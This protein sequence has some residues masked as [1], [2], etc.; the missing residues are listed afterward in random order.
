MWS[1]GFGDSELAVDVVA[2]AKE[3]A[4]GAQSAGVVGAGSE[5]G[6]V[7]VCAD[8]DRCVGLGNSGRAELIKI[9]FA[10]AKEFAVPDGA[11]VVGADAD[12]GGGFGAADPGGCALDGVGSI[13]N[14]CGAPAIGFVVAGGA[15]A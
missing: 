4:A 14:R 3:V 12:I 6:P 9:V 8:L 11:G 13:A 5:L 1:E 2:P 10:P 15:G 7:V